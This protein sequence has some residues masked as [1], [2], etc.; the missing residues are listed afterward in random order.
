MRDRVR[1]DTLHMLLARQR[2]TRLNLCAIQKM[3]EGVSNEIVAQTQRLND[4]DADEE[5]GA[6]SSRAS[7]TA[8]AVAAQG[9]RISRSVR[10]AV[11]SLVAELFSM[12][13]TPRL[14]DQIGAHR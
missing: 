13:F 2:G 12:T 3:I 14:L 9:N 11:G 6:V 5:R 4:R 10:P 1:L 8:L 7:V